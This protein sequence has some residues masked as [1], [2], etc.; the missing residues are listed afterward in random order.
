MLHGFKPHSWYQNLYCFSIA[1][2]TS[3]YKL[4]DLKQHQFIIL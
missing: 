4:N 3:D 2:V 1:A